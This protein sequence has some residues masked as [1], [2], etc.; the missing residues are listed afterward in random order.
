V[1]TVPVALVIAAG[2]GLAAWQGVSALQQDEAPAVAVPAPVAGP[3]PDT[4]TKPAAAARADDA[5]PQSSVAA[6]PSK[7]ET[8]MAERVAVLGVLNKRN[9]LARDITLTP[10]RAMRIGDLVVR[11]R[12]CEETPPWEPERLTGAFVQTDVLGRDARWRRV[13][14]GWLYKE[15]PSLNAVQH[16]IY[17]VWPKSCTMRHPEIGPDTIAAGSAGSGP[18]PRRSIAPKSPSTTPAAPPTPSAESSNAT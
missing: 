13:F 4:N 7:T 14:S 6:A 10:G 17:D 12:A 5:S 16:P 15:S 18:A 3:D 9:G 8:P 11:L 2:L 1:K